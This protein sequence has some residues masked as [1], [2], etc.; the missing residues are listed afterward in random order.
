[1]GSPF[2]VSKINLNQLGRIE[3]SDLLSLYPSAPMLWS[4]PAGG[5]KFMLKLLNGSLEFCLDPV[6]FFFTVSR[7]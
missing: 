5:S 1:M 2:P 6:R 7:S 4:L 3:T